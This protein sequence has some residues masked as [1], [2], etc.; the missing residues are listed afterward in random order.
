M[1]A[2]ASEATGRQVERS[3]STGC[4]R[5]CD[6]AFT[7]GYTYRPKANITATLWA[8]SKLS[9]V[10]SGPLGCGTW[11]ISPSVR[12]VLLK[13][14]GTVSRSCCGE[15]PEQPSD[16]T[17]S[18]PVRCW[19]CLKARADFERLGCAGSRITRAD[20]ASHGPTAQS[21][22]RQGTSSSLGGALARPRRSAREAGKR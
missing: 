2:S 12:A 22:G 13:E 6:R 16:S 1:R 18:S 10:W 5:A 14:R 15:P 21:A 4:D 9:P 7:G 3:R 19:R 11:S 8:S 20:G 17:V